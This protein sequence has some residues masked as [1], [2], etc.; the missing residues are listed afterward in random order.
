MNPGRAQQTEARR[1]SAHPDARS[2]VGT[3][4]DP[5]LRTF[6]LV[7][8]LTYATTATAEEPSCSNAAK[9]GLVMQRYKEIIA[10]LG[11]RASF[12]DFD[13]YDPQPRLRPPPPRIGNLRGPGPIGFSSEDLYPGGSPRE[14]TFLWHDAPD[15][16]AGAG[17]RDTH[18][19]NGPIASYISSSSLK[20]FGYVNKA[21]MHYLEFRFDR[22]SV[23]KGPKPERVFSKA[24]A[25]S[26]C[27]SYLQTMLLYDVKDLVALEGPLYDEPKPNYSELETLCD[28]T[29]PC[30]PEWD[31]R[32]WRTAQGVFSA[33]HV[34]SCTFDAKLGPTHI[35]INYDPAKPLPVLKARISEE[36]AKKAALAAVAALA[37]VVKLGPD[38]FRP[39]VFTGIRL[40]YMRPRN[41]WHDHLVADFK[42]LPGGLK[43]VKYDGAPP[44]WEVRFEV[45]PREEAVGLGVFDMWIDLDAQT[46]QLLDVDSKRVRDR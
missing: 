5:M 33:D 18:V 16:Y 7:L 2:S 3:K 30:W 45:K 21:L 15:D 44:A 29:Q 4:W 37:S 28:R 20:A 27:R 8:G 32:F 11:G 17:P 40:I 14:P 10:A 38:S 24:E 9:D 41:D 34:A 26:R 42:G 19:I 22:Y 46:G 25:E 43:F 36:A 23:G 1:S 35:W 31:V 6:S 12:P 13:P 39:P